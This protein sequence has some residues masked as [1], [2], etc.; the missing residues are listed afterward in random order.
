VK[1]K[2]K[3]RRTVGQ[4]KAAA[5][6]EFS[7]Y[8]RLRDSLATTGTLTECK[9]IT[10]GEVV[11]TKYY[12]GC[13]NSLQAGHAIDGRGKNILFDEEIVNGQCKV[14]NCVRNGRLSEYALIMIER[15]GKDWF[16]ERC[17][18]ARKPAEKPWNVKDLDEIRDYYKAKISE[19][20]G[21]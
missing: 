20:R 5:W 12:K 13:K 14:C 16:D 17:R 10:C 8:V 18:L 3:K 2:P 4:A 6:K 21:A 19:L 9:C 7:M 15:Y 1:K 11:P